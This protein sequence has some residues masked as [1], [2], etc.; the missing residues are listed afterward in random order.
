MSNVQGEKPAFLLAGGRNTDTSM[1]VRLL[2]RSLLNC[3]TAAYIGAANGDSEAFFELTKSLLQKLG[4]KRIEFV[5]TATEKADTGKAIETL[6]DAD[7]IYISGGE[8]EDGMK[9]L[10]KHSLCEIIRDIYNKGKQFICV[11]AGTIMM[12]THWISVDETDDY[13]KAELFDCLK[14]IPA[15]FDTHAEDEDW[16]ELKTTLKLLGDGSTGYGIRTGGILS[17]SIDG[18]LVSVN[19]ELLEIKFTDKGFLVKEIKERRAESYG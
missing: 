18:R 14:I 5:K 10:K 19:K 1:I 12:G 16:I 11:S 7:V 3:K 15:V 4:L 9:W 6:Y 13:D 17:A 2:G 8:V